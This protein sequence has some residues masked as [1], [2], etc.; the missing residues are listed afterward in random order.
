MVDIYTPF[1]WVCSQGWNC[2][3]NYVAL[4]LSGESY[5]SI[6]A[7]TFTN[8]ATQE[9]KDR[10]LLFLDNIADNTGNDAANALKAVRAR[11]IR[12]HSASDDDLRK[13]ARECYTRMLEDYDNIHISTI[14]TF[15]MQLLN[16]LGQMLDNASAG[17][18]VELDIEHLITVAVDRLLTRPI[19]P[20]SDM[21][22]RL[23]S[24]TLPH[25]H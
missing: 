15:L 8:K 7:V 13:L 9:M 19:E 16:G 21:L 6:L 17:A 23:S 1:S 11:M 18:E 4:L 5:R 3:L 2:W 20:Q 10:I 24:L 14:D 25:G 22:V 12:N